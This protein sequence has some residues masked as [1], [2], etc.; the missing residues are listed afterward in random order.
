[1]ALS[2]WSNAGCIAA[3]AVQSADWTAHLPWQPDATFIR[4]QLGAPN[5]DVITLSNAEWRD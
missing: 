4:A 2:V 1:L 5:G 3:C